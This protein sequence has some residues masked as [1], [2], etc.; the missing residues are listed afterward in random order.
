MKLRTL[1]CCT[2][3]GVLALAWT[4]A[5]SQSPPSLPHLEKRGAVTQ[6]V[7]DG[8]PYLALAGELGNNT[9]STLENMRPIWPNLVKANLNTV[10][11]AVAWSWIE[12]EEGRFDFTLVD[13]LIREARRN[14]LHLV[15]LWFGSWKNGTS[16]YPPAW[17]KREFER[18]P[19]V[20]GQDGKGREILTALS[21]V[22]C[23][24]DARAFAAFLRHVKEVD[25]SRHTVIL[26]QVENEVGVLGL[27]RDFSAAANAAFAQPAPGELMDFL[28]KHKNT[29]LPE[30]LKV[31]EA[32]GFKTAGTWEEVFGAGA[33]A[34]EI[35]MAWNY[36]RYMD[37]VAEA[38][39][40]EYPLPMYV[41][42][43]IVQPRDKQ[44]GDYPSGGPQ[45]HLH[46]IWRAGAPH[47]DIL[48][49]D[50]YLTNFAEIAAR[51]SRSGN[52]LFI[53]ETRADAA[54]LFYA[55]GHLNAQM[56]S[57]FGIE[58]QTDPD[59]PFARSYAVLGQ[60]APLI[61]ANQG[62]GTMESVVLE[63]DNPTNTVS[64]GKYTFNISVARG[65]GGAPPAAG[66]GAGGGRGGRGRGAGAATEGPPAA[67]LAPA[68]GGGFGQTAAPSR[69]FGLLIQ[70]GPDDYWVAGSGLSISAEP[71]PPGPPLASLA[72][73]EEGAFENG[74]W[75]VGR[76]LAGDDT[77]Q[78]GG[79]RA[80]LR[81]P[82]NRVGILRVQ[83]YR[84]R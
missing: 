61:L 8:R 3:T 67:Q 39:K 62:K 22:N 9:S 57:P 6:L 36:A 13:G 1:T 53:P 54:N 12:P 14:N 84:Y 44:P 30:F 23:Q 73:V 35:F 59:T 66:R 69:A 17:V 56:F 80:S 26:I 29:L 46:D 42:A 63:A 50:I 79:E 74:R 15:F 10:L 7:V 40:K 70:V 20:Q 58:R 52:P 18:F 21:E 47:I 77:G 72:S 33:A 65:R 55:V 45:D 81:L 41:N 28:Q 34:D 25:G 43:W 16:S 32:A 49:P 19:L 76:R 78:G 37:R 48:A 31:W 71:N 24:A 68:G 64:L 11:A 27:S 83:L 51:Y 82:A 38:G 60:L 5:Q 4:R 2:L 75:V